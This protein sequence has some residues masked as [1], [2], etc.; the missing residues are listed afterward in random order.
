MGLLLAATG[1]LTAAL[2]VAAGQI[3]LVGFALAFAMMGIAAWDVAMN[4]Q[5]TVVERELDHAIM[6]RFHAGF[7]VGAVAGA[8]GGAAAAAG[9]LPVS[10]HLTLAVVAVALAVWVLTCAYL[11][12]RAMTA[13]SHAGDSCGA[14]RRAFAAWTEPRTVL[15]GLMV[16]AAALT[17]GS[18][19]DWLALAVVDGFSAS[20][21]F[22]ALAFGLFVGS[23]TLMRFAG[24]RLLDRHGRVLILRLSA[25]LAIVGVVA[26]ALVPSLTTAL[27][28]VVLWGFG[29]ALGFPVGMSAASDDP[30]HSAARVSVV[31]TIGYVAFLAGPPL[32]GMLADQIGYRY[33][34]LT[35]AIPLMGSLLLAPVAAPLKVAENDRS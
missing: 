24:T 22:G 33:A 30:A 19:N 25:A 2:G 26:F 8:L 4:L 17:E 28:A 9:G 14:R 32:L 21:A 18:A 16:L 3:L 5:G 7:S 35:I 27:I 1:L 13:P 11:P 10:W 20:N 31:S 6:P 29:A 23:M 15:I 12:D 34:L